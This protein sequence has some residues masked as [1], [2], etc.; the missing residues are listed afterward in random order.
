[1]M[2]NQRFKTISN[3]SKIYFNGS[4][5]QNKCGEMTVIGK[6]T[7]RRYFIV[8]FKDNFIKKVQISNIK[9]GEVYNPCFPAVHNTGFA[10]QGIHKVSINR[11]P[12]KEYYLWNSMITRCYSKKSLEILPTYIDCS[13]VKRWHNFQNFCDDIPK[14]K[15][16]SNWVEGCKENRNPYQLDKDIKIKGNRIYSKETCLFITATENSIKAHL[17]GKTYQGVNPKGKSFTFYNISKFSNDNNLAEGCVN[18]CILK[19]QHTHKG[20][21]FK[22]LDNGDNN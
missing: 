9:T 16:Y 4:K 7:E 21:T 3:T 8:Q 5:W 17:T 12:T 14:I 22:I 15:G 10:G 19:K 1:M 2:T 13:V 18:D 20:W 11:K 6:S